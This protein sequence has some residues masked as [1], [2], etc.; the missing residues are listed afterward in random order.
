[1]S[2][3]RIVRIAK[4]VVYKFFV[5]NIFYS[6]KIGTHDLEEVEMFARGSA[7]AHNLIHEGLNAKPSRVRSKER[8]CVPQRKSSLPMEVLFAEFM[9]NLDRRGRFV[10]AE[11]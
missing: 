1:M 7:K 5:C 8:K 6:G 10:A 4:R 3:V 11:A 9:P 2:I